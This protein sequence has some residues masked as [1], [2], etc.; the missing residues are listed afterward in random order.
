MKKFTEFVKEST[1]E[2]AQNDS[3]EV[4][5][6][7]KHLMGKAKEYDDQADREKHFGHGGAKCDRAQLLPELQSD[8]EPPLPPV[9][10]LRAQRRRVRA[11]AVG[12][13][14]G[15]RSQGKR[16]MVAHAVPAGCGDGGD[17]VA[18]ALVV[19]QGGSRRWRPNGV[20]L[21]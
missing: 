18:A 10:Y 13:A 8:C 3:K 16:G 6:Q 12:G 21:C 15:L 2:T 1:P 9:T 17:V 14:K 19:E 4:A 11:G 5:R 20:N 7:K